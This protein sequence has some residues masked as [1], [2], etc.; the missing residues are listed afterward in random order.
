[1]YQSLLAN[2]DSD[3]ASGKGYERLMKMRRIVPIADMRYRIGE[4]V[5]ALLCVHWLLLMADSDIA[6]GKTKMATEL[7][8]TF[9][10]LTKNFLSFVQQGLFA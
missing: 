3:I 4:K 10:D 9:L 1:M 6:S 2:A 5:C 7:A 8:I